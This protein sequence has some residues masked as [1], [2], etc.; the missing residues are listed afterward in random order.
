MA[1][2]EHKSDFNICRISEKIDRV[3][4]ILHCSDHIFCNVL[5]YS[6][7]YRRSLDTFYLDTAPMC[8][9]KSE[10]KIV[11]FTMPFIVNIVVN[12]IQSHVFVPESCFDDE[13][14]VV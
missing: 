7:S 2:A 8:I 10:T 12:S 3:I 6:L 1:T 9:S 11:I 4:T 14:K 5:L 13:Y